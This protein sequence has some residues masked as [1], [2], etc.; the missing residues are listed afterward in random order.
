M[1]IKKILLMIMAVLICVMCFTA[2]EEE[3][4]ASKE[5]EN[6]NKM[7]K[8][9]YS[10]ITLTVTDKFDEETSLVSKYEMSY[11]D[12]TVTVDYTVERFNQ[13]SLDKPNE[14]VKSTII[15]EAVIEN[16]SSVTL[17]SGD[18]VITSD[19][20]DIDFDFKE[21][22]FENAELT[23]LY[24]KADVKDANSF[25]KTSLSCKD[26]KV[27][28]EFFDA[29]YQIKVTYTIENGTQVEYNYEFTL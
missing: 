27:Y 6:L 5:Y 23:S 1:E 19:I 24:L 12:K 11:S 14:S 15:G 22:Y 25:M 2:C 21:E 29:F 7:L 17:N 8:S 26:M 3:S 13:I 10:K 16:G 9:Y 20:A 18:V 4:S 28:A